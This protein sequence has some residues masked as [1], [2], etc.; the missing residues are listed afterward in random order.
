MWPPV[1]TWTDSLW[2]DCAPGRTPTSKSPNERMDMQKAAPHELKR[3]AGARF[4]AWTTT[5]SDD[6]PTRP[7]FLRRVNVKHSRCQIAS[8]IKRCQYPQRIEA[9]RAYSRFEN[10]SEITGRSDRDKTLCCRA[11]I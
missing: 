5:I 10:E 7:C 11:A 2:L 9:V 3:H 6:R 4:L 1:S 8:F